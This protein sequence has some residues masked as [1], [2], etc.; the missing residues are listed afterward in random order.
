MSHLITLIILCVIFLIIVTLR[1][2]I[3]KLKYLKFYLPD[4]SENHVVAPLNIQI[5]VCDQLKK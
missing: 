1:K 4:D 2:R 3:Q 5:V